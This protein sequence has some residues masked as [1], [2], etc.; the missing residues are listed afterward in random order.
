MNISKTDFKILYNTISS[1]S[2]NE[3]SIL[4][5]NINQNKISNPV[6]NSMV[7]KYS[8]DDISNVIN[9]INTKLLFGGNN[10]TNILSTLAATIV[11]DDLA[12]SG[13]KF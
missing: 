8:V 6:I 11:T 12:K 9:K 7:N 5:A 3:L 2:Q 10:H 4:V 1:L 13:Y